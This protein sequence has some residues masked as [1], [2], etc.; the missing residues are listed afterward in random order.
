MF[1][2]QSLI[3]KEC[4]AK[5]CVGSFSMTFFYCGGNKNGDGCVLFR[6]NSDTFRSND[7]F[8]I[9]ACLVPH[10]TDCFSFFLLIKSRQIYFHQN[11]HWCL[12]IYNWNLCNSDL[13]PQAFSV[14]K[15]LNVVYETVSSFPSSDILS[16]RMLISSVYQLSSIW[17][18]HINT[19]CLYK[20]CSSSYQIDFVLISRFNEC[21]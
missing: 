1:P 15:R 18:V 19:W 11:R 6:D 17:F 9:S 3:N 8:Q 7:R 2:L 21:S 4:L 13:E 16:L 14:K 20:H 5:T 12:T 10:K